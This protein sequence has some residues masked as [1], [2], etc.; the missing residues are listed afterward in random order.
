MKIIAGNWKMNGSRENLV[1]M[2]AALQNIETENTVVLCVPYTMLGVTSDNIALGAQDVSTHDHGAYTGEVSAQMVADTGA[3][4]TIVGHSERRQYHGETNDIVRQKAASALAA[5]LT[6]II[7]VGETMDEKQAGKTMEI[8]ESGV[9]ES[10]PNDVNGKIIVAYEPRWAIG[11]GLTPTD[12]EIAAAHKLIADTLS[13]IGLDGTPVLYGASV[14]GSNAAQ[15]MSIPNVDG[16]LVG[17][18]SL[19]PD[20]FIPIITSVK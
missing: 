15:I 20:D 11:A 9:R 17:G 1:N 5:G 2:V 6:P 14:K 10:I 4:Y 12:E 16:V 18:A 13:D 8:I 19:K 7:C 3:K